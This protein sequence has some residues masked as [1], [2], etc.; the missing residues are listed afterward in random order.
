L[1]WLQY[2]VENFLELWGYTL[3]GAVEWEG[4]ESGDTGRIVVLDNVIKLQYVKLSWQD[5]EMA[6]C[7]DEVQIVNEKEEEKKMSLEQVVRKIIEDFCKDL[8]SFTSLDV[9]NAVKQDGFAD[10]RHREVAQLVREAHADGIMEDYSYSRT[11]IDVDLANGG[12]AQAYLYH[13]QSA[14]PQVYNKRSQVA[15]PPVAISPVATP[16]APTA[17]TTPAPHST[18]FGQVIGTPSTSAALATSI[19]CARYAQD[20]KADGRLEIPRDFVKSLDCSVI[21]MEPAGGALV[22]RP[23]VGGSNIIYSIAVDKWGRI[24]VPKTVLRRAGLQGHSYE[25]SLNA[26][27]DRIRIEA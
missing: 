23:F 18:L 5:V 7:S 17:V 26:A 22:V 24:R 11:L 8:D 4:E 15:I 14:N 21:P 1:E 3:N 16:T 20:A 19:S 2:I 13:H 6:F 25:I 12:S 9:S 27:G 10:V